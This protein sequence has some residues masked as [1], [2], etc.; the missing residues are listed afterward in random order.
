MDIPHILD[1]LHMMDILHMCPRMPQIG[2]VARFSEGFRGGM[3]WVY[4]LY[5]PCTYLVYTLNLCVQGP[6]ILW[7]STKNY[8]KYLN[9]KNV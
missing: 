5:T 1:I 3:Y 7:I 4:T 6:P 9:S 2:T 8:N